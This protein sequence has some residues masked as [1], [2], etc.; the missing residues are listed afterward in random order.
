MRH[1]SFLG[2]VLASCQHRGAQPAQPVK[3]NNVREPRPPTLVGL[4]VHRPYAEK[5]ADDQ[6]AFFKDYA[7]AHKK[8][9]ENGAKW[10][11]GGPVALD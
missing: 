2:E 3:M 4:T 1:A 8:L 7:A 11:E 6:E 9:S 10:A 5:Y